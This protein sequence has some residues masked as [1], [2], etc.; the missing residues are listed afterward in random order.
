MVTP[1]MRTTA[2]LLGF[3]TPAMRTTAVLLGFFKLDKYAM[4]S[5]A[6]TSGLAS[7]SD[8]FKIIITL[9]RVQKFED[10]GPYKNLI[11]LNNP[12]TDNFFLEIELNAMGRICPISLKGLSIMLDKSDLLSIML[13]KYLLSNMLNKSDTD[14]FS[15]IRV[16]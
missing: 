11:F 5:F 3:L 1:A 16:V 7:D 14:I 15:N 4:F 6:M 9:R 10:M 8:K 2:V 13:N 12:L